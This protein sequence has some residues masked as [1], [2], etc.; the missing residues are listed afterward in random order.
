MMFYVYVHKNPKSNEIF[1]VGKGCGKR[2]YS[3][4]NRNRHWQSKVSSYGGFNVHFLAKELDQEFA[5]LMEMEVIDLYRKV[6]CKLANVTNGGDGI[7]GFKHSEET[8]QKIAKKATGRPGKFKSENFTPEMRQLIIESNKR[9][10]F[11][12]TMKEKCTFAGKSH[13]EEHKNYM[14]EKMK[15]RV[16][17]AETL[18]KMSAAQKLRFQKSK[19]HED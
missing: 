7:Q 6:G 11:T 12:E 1:Y 5:F 19:K 3:K 2:A 10:E 18:A 14:K 4:H 9:R 15:G 16:F 13:T 17:S 8:K